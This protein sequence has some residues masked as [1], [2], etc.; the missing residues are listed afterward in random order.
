M[1]GHSGRNGGSGDSEEVTGEWMRANGKVESQAPNP[2]TK[3]LTHGKG[4]AWRDR[5]TN[6]QVRE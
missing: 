5:P 3:C 6:T 1:L 4:S 2:Q